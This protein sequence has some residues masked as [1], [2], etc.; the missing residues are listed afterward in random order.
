MQFELGATVET[1]QGKPVGKLHRVVINPHSEEVSHLGIRKGLLFSEHKVLPIE[2]VR[3]ARKESIVLW[4]DEDGLESLPDF[5][6]RYY[7]VADEHELVSGPTSTTPSALYVRPYGYQS[8]VPVRPR[9]TNS[10]LE[11]HVERNISHEDVPLE[12]GAKVMDMN[13]DEIGRVKEVLTDPDLDRA[14]HFVISRGLLFE[15]EIQIPVERVREIDE[16]EVKLALSVD[17]L[18]RIPG[19][20]G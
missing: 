3:S 19:Q 18:E 15:E 11:E 4:V 13:G 14:T 16:A 7:V 20:A 5:E 8:P 12:K 6:E 17:I 1:S 9:P 2:L 10:G